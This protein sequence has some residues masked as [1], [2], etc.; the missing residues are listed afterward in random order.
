MAHIQ[1]R[2]DSFSVRW[3]EG[4][5]KRRRTFTGKAQGSATKAK[6]AAEQ[7]AVEIERRKESGDLGYYRGLNMA[8]MD[9]VGQEWW[10]RHAELELEPKT[11]SLYSW[12]WN[13]HVLPY[14]G[15]YEMREI[16]AGTIRDWRIA[17]QKSGLGDPTIRKA[18]SLLQGIFRW[19]A[20]DE[21][22]PPINPVQVVKKPSAKRT[23]KIKPLSAQNIE[24]VRSQM[25][26]LS[27]KTLV[28]ILAYAGLRPEEA[29][30]LTWGHIRDNTILVDQKLV[31]GEIMA[32][33]KTQK[34]RTVDLLPLLADDIEA[35]RQEAKPRSDDELLFARSD[36]KPWSD[37]DRQ[38]WRKRVFRKAMN[39]AGLEGRIYDLRH[40]FASALIQAGHKPPYV[41]EQL[42]HSIATSM[43]T[44]QHVFEEVQNPDDWQDPNEEIRKARR[45]S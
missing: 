14:L 3:L 21:L 5:R 23:V 15:S 44:Y 42:G 20:E 8:L 19:A 39:K 34:D 16:R 9:L 32:G 11:L 25:D 36:G 40:S 33:T 6:K 37:S 2:G 29:L 13:K 7:F 28:S 10:P 45:G 31:Q 22:I 24:A 12:L 38:N 43:D 26:S 30:A 17:L 1:Q 35:L 41:A 18:M 4:G 27:D